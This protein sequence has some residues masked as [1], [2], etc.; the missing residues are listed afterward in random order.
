MKDNT[1]SCITV[2]FQSMNEIPEKLETFLDSYFE[3]SGLNYTPENKEQYVGYATLSFNEKDLL[4]AAKKHKIVLPS[5]KIEVLKNKNWLT[6]NVIKFE[7]KEI[8]DFCVYG[9]HE[10]QKPH[11]RKIPIKVYAATAFGSTHQTTQMCLNAVADLAKFSFKPQNIIDVGTGSGILSIAVA[12]KFKKLNPRI[13]GVDIDR[14][15]INVAAQNAY[16]NNVQNLF[17]VS[18]SNGFKAKIVKQNAPYNLAFA[19]ILARPLISMAKDMHK[20]L[21]PKGFAVLSGFTADQTDWVLNTYQKTGFKLIKL[22][23]N[24]HW[25]AALLQKKENISNIQSHLKAGQSFLIKRD[26]MF[27]GEDV[28]PQENKILELS[29]FT[30]SAGMMLITQKKVFL[31]V[32][33]RYSIQAR[34]EAFKGIEVVDSTNFYTDIVR[35]Y[36]QNNLKTLNFNPL[37]VSKTEADFFKNEGLCLDPSFEVPASTLCPP[38]K[39][40]KHPVKYAGLS[41]KEKC[42]IILKAMPKTY[43]ALFISSAMD[44]SWLSNLRAVDL[45]DTPVLRAFALLKKDGSLKVYSFEKIKNL[46]N[47]LNKCKNVIVDENKTPLAVLNQISHHKD[48]GF[49]AL[50]QA[51]LQKNQTELN[52]FIQSHIRDGAALVKF[53][54]WLENHYNGLTELDVVQKLHE[55]RKQNKNYFSES[56]GTIAAINSNAA[57]VHYQPTL[58]TNKKFSKNALLLLDS[59]AEYF[60][61]TTDITR[62]VS[63]G[64]I[65]SQIKKDFTLV[66]KAHIALASHVFKE[67]TPANQLDFVCRQILQTQGKDFKHGTGHSVGHFSN[68][69]EPPFSI[70]QYN[71]IPVSAHEITSIEPG[72][73]KENA[74][75]IRIENLVYTTPAQKRGYLR[76]EP[77]TLCPIDLNLIEPDMLTT[78]EKDW[79]NTYH[80]KVFDT[81][82]PFLNKQEQ[83]W[84]KQKCHSV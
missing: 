14:E 53:F 56:F 20:S 82:K 49:Q 6:E 37:V 42:Q 55:F 72:Y 11:T 23:Q 44:V 12:K 38:Q 19:N 28:L 48:I 25:R 47:D 67:K 66:L 36:Q 39:V 31:L 64:R 81:L 4:K 8:A 59:G 77:L 5:Y 63:F 33:G 30:G 71:T 1:S 73:Y 15:S 29:G 21:T 70:N 83:K 69:H 3:V 78:I 65:N 46:I 84:L 75:G 79:L 16:D 57:I 43:D 51:K 54:F 34:K 22:Y 35:L 9:I 41:S 68:V 60:D 32:D 74:Y 10:K 17:D 58:K 26:N 80:A 13:L 52:G 45:P 76:F 24:E 7:P 40:F 27:L 62:T 50:S 2:T 61:G 18:Y